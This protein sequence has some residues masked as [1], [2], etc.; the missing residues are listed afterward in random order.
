MVNRAW[1]AMR[2]SQGRCRSRRSSSL[3]E[4]P[5]LIFDVKNTFIGPVD[6]YSSR[7]LPLI[8]Q[9]IKYFSPGAY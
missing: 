4:H 1:R 9:D 7:T 2:I 5:S 3:D 6:G 8:I